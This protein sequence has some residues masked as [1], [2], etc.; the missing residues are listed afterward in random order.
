MLKTTTIESEPFEMP[1]LSRYWFYEDGRVYNK[2]FKINHKLSY[3][4][5]YAAY[6][7]I[8][9]DDKYDLVYQKEIILYVKHLKFEAKNIRL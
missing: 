8:G 1:C 7:L 6:K 9:D 4:G 2:K 5:E 3:T